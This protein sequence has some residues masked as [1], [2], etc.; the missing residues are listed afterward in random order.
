MLEVGDP[1]PWFQARVAAALDRFAFDTVAGRWVVMLFAGCAGPAQQR[2]LALLAQ[3]RA[4]FDDHHA[5]FFGV[6]V[7]PSDAAEGRIARLLPGVRWFL[8]YDRA[9]SGLFGAAGDGT[10]TKYEPHW[11][12]LDPMLRVAARA[13]LDEGD[14]IFFALEARL[15]GPQQSLGAPVLVVPNILPPE[16]CRTLIEH[17]EAGGGAPSGYMSDDA[18]LTTHK[19]DSQFKRRSDHYIDDEAVIV[20]IKARLTRVLHPLMRRAFQFEATRVERWLVACYDSNDKGMFRPHRDN[21]TRGT[22]H[23]K[24]ACTINLNAEDY[25]GGDLRFPEF[26]TQDYRAPT[27][28]AVVFSCSLLHEARPVTRGRR[29]AF[30]PF[31]YDDE[32][33]RLR[34][35]NLAFVTPDLRGYRSG[36]DRD[37]SASR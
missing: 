21:T 11:L 29:F 15:R 34:E 30:L 3:H 22:A 8:D 13:S 17:Y 2:A 23:R 18:G 16:L 6:T 4:L 32:G 27:G 35:R 25:D 9:I 19:L 5:I 26:G 37:E 31:F 1:A 10:D 12:L 20:A 7:D 33:A 28:G 14:R 24:F 36:M